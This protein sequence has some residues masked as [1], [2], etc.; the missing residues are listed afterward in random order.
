[1]SVSVG[2]KSYPSQISQNQNSVPQN[3]KVEVGKVL[4]KRI[5]AF[6]MGIKF[7]NETITIASKKGTRAICA[8]TTFGAAVSGML[9]GNVLKSMFLG[10]VSLKETYDLLM[11]DGTLEGIKT[12]LK[13]N[14]AGLELTDEIL[15]FNKLILNQASTEVSSITKNLSSL[16]KDL[17]QVNELSDLGRQELKSEKEVL[18]VQYHEANQEYALAQN[19]FRKSQKNAEKANLFFDEMMKGFGQIYELSQKEVAEISQAVKIAEDMQKNCIEA[20]KK[21]KKCVDYQELAKKH[22]DSANEMYRHASMCYGNLLGKTESLLL[23]INEKNSEAQK[24]LQEAQK[25]NEAHSKNVEQLNNNN[26][27]LIK[28]N[29]RL[30]ENNAQL[31]DEANAVHSY[32]LTSIICGAIPGALAG[33]S[34]GPGGAVVGGVAGLEAVHNRHAIARKTAD[35]LFGIKEETAIDFSSGQK[36]AYKFDDH[37]SGYFGR[38]FFRRASKTVGTI[39]LKISENEHFKMRFNLNEKHFVKDA[40][41]KELSNLLAEKLRSNE[42]SIAECME[43]IKSLEELTIHSKSVAKENSHFYLLKNRRHS[44]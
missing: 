29:E 44:I 33:N 22:A 11:K 26:A 20:Q 42:L 15:Q 12:L 40:D 35:W 36:L 2:Y 39:A 31:I 17:H 25:Q 8:A 18:I 9:E 21:M 13:E 38:Y 32:G 14:Q 37:S 5:T 24:K 6:V 4:D 7:L 41:L 43:I 30:L 19:F 3:S 10:A 1:M 27:E 28:V 23:Q 16:E 34:F